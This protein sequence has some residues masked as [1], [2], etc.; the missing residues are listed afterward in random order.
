MEAPHTILLIDDDPLVRS[1]C[2]RILEHAGYLIVTAGDG[3]T[4]LGLLDSNDA[5]DLVVMDL[6]MPGMNGA[7]VLDELHRS[8]TQIPVV[9][10]SG[11]TDGMLTNEL[12][13]R[14]AGFLSK[15]FS[16]SRLTSMVGQAL[17]EA[18]LASHYAGA[19]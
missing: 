12:H 5:I 2:R 18:P 13:S 9:V 4:A 16:A 14:L 17:R 11:Y 6:V 15:P 1:T 19:Y 10:M 7:A 8:S 3:A